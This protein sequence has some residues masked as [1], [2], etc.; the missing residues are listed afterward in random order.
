MLLRRYEQVALRAAN[1][2]VVRGTYHK[3]HLDALGIRVS[4]V[5]QDGVDVLHFRPFDVPD[6][7]RTLGLDVELTVGVLGSLH[8]S[9]RLHWTTGMELV[10]ALAAFPSKTL[11][12][13]V[14]GD[15]SGLPVLRQAAKRLGVAGRVHFVGQIPYSAL[16]QYINC[17][18]VCLSTQT[19]D[20]VGWVRTT[21]KLPLFLA[22]GRFVLASRVGEAA[23]ILP[24]EM[25]VEYVSSFDNTY[26]SR[27]A[28]HI[29]RI[30]EK[31]ELLDLG[32]QSRAIAEAEFDYRILAPRVASVL[33]SVLDNTTLRR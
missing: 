18:D 27:L 30:L 1:G 14:V 20:L 7:R 15:G 4:A 12:G 33:R 6:L 29:R 10:E 31:P 9:P 22:C 23:R 28:G 32:K 19:N 24:E 2:V 21:G 26:P 16:P 13:L 17:M 11:L 25:L 5:I 8:W 3:E